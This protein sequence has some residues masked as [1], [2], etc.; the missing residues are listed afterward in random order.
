MSEGFIIGGVSKYLQSKIETRRSE[1]YGNRSGIHHSADQKEGDALRSFLHEYQDAIHHRDPDTYND[2]VWVFDGEDELKKFVE[3]YAQKKY[4]IRGAKME[5]KQF[6]GFFAS[7]YTLDVNEIA[8]VSDDAVTK[9]A[10]SD[11]VKRLD[12]SN[13]PPLQR[14]VENPSL[15][16]SGLY[17]MQEQPGR[18]RM[19]KKRTSAS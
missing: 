19:R 18:S 7:L 8:Y 13:L 17:F 2:Q 12:F 3:E 11:L 1:H 10:L 5:Q 15:Q 6:G 4:L 9:I 16:L 14:P